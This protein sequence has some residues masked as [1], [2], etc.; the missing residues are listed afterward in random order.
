MKVYNQQCKKPE[1]TKAAMRDV[2]KDLV[3]R[4][5]MTP[6]KSLPESVQKGIVNAPVRHYHPWRAV[7]KDDSTTTPVRL[8]VDASMT[9]LNNI[10]AKGEN[11]ISRA[12]E[13]IVRNRLKRYAFSTDITKMYNTQ[14]GRASCRER[15]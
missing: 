10:L 14:I 6:L 4:G 2:H 1:E 5:F 3:D 13:I 8:V 7:H 11:R 12:N 9:K 15:V